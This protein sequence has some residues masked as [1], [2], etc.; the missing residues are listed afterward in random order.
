MLTEN[1][2]YETY[3]EVMRMARDY[4]ASC[5]KSAPVRKAFRNKKRDTFFRRV[6]IPVSKHPVIY[7]YKRGA[8]GNLPYRTF[9][10]VEGSEGESFVASTARGNMYQVMHS[11]AINRYMQRSRFEGTFDEARLKIM[12]Y[13]HYYYISKDYTDDTKYVYFDGGMFICTVDGNIMHFRTFIMNRQCHLNQR[14]LSLESEKGR[15][16][17]KEKFGLT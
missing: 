7:E 11:H 6:N 1:E 15:E 5:A 4:G 9:L 2:T 10:V 14:M 12:D 17:A 16:W 3:D 13:L 8:D